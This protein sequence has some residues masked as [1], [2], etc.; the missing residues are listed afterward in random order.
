M[1]HEAVGLTGLVLTKLDGTAKGGIVVRIYQELGVPI[2]LVGVGEQIED[3]Q[4]FD[5]K[6]FVDAL[7]GERM[8]TR[9]DDVRPEDFRF[10]AHG[11]RAGPPRGRGLTS[12]NPVVGAL[13]VRR[14]RGRGGVH[15]R[16]GE[17]HAEVGWRWPRPGPRARG[18]TLYVTLEPC[19]HTGRTPPCV[20]A[21]LA[22][23]IRRVVVAIADPNPRVRGGGAAALRAAGVEVDLGCLEAEARALNRAFFTAM[24]RRA[25]AR[26]AQVGHDARRQDRR[27]RSARR[28][29][30]PE[31]RRALEAHRLR[32]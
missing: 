29:G 14:A 30:S 22:A 12:P 18:A 10:M 27:L 19:N 15:R 3:L 4:P 23:G 31:R 21:V 5:P 26:H 24:E 9:R 11:P 16:A 2:K 1:F 32:S 20:E 28:D 17:A 25:P 8:T 7:I 13:V 6:T